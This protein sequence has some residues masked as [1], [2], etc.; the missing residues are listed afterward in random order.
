[1]TRTAT[2]PGAALAAAYESWSWV[3]GTRNHESRQS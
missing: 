3:T 1:M 2:A